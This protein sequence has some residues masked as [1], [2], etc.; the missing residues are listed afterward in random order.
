MAVRSH[1][2]PDQIE[3][4]Q[5]RPSQGRRQVGFVAARG[6]LGVGGVRLHAVDL[7]LGQ[8]HEVQE[9]GARHAVVRL[10]ARGRHRA[11][12]PP[13]HVGPMPGVV[14]V[15]LFGHPAVERLGRA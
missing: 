12:V 14:Q 2:Q 5:L 8:R 3:H 4:R 15:G 11:L 6:A 13:P 10:R 7:V 9:R 1:S